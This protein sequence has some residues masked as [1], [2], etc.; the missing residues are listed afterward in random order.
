MIP[1]PTSETDL[2]RWRHER[3]RNSVMIVVLVLAILAL[4]FWFLT[5][6]SSPSSP[7]RQV[8]HA[9]FGRQ[10]TEAAERLSGEGGGTA[11]S[12]QGSQA[13]QAGAPGG[14][15]GRPGQDGQNEA[16]QTGTNA[17]NSAERVQGHGTPINGPVGGDANPRLPASNPPERP[18]RETRSIGWLDRF[19]GSPGTET[20]SVRPGEGGTGENQPGAGNTNAVTTTP[21]NA[22]AAEFTES[23]P[24][25]RVEITLDEPPSPIRSTNR[26]PR[27]PNALNDNFE[28]LLRQHHAGSGDVRISLMWNNR[29]DLDLHVVEPRGE[30]IFYL[31]RESESGGLLDIDMNAGPPF[32][33]PAVENVYW[34]ERAAPP[35]NYRVYVNH[36]RRQDTPDLT[37]FTVRV[38]VRGRTTDVTGHIRFGEPKKLV[39]QFNLPGARR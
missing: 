34:P 9:I 19:F 2:A 38:L 39:Y 11:E 36:Y 16:G 27:A 5:H 14:S 29:N 23:D 24:P 7:A 17:A 31:H 3:R 1:T 28:E 35:G 18:A 30:E 33:N 13:A 4:L 8:K 32:R 26:A 6:H 10:I 20:A 12:G 25:A 22:V 21:T 37:Q 15:L